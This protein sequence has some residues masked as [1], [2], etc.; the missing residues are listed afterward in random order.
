MVAQWLS[1]YGDG[2]IWLWT[3]WQM[4]FFTQK[5]LGED[6]WTQLWEFALD[7]TLASIPSVAKLILHEKLKLTVTTLG[8]WVKELRVRR[9]KKERNLENLITKGVTKLLK[10]KIHIRMELHTSWSGLRS[11]Q[12]SFH[13]LLCNRLLSRQ[14]LQDSAL[15]NWG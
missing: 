12:A 5:P 1:D 15:M 11:S 4:A 10:N 14:S 3:S 6:I 7:A 8:K 9:L 13:L 2:F